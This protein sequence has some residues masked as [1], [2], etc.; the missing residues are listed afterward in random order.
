DQFPLDS[1]FEVLDV[2][3]TPSPQISGPGLADPA[4]SFTDTDGDG[5]ADLLVIDF[6]AVT[7]APD[8]LVD[9][10]DVLSVDVLAL[11]LDDPANMGGAGFVNTATLDFG[12]GTASDTAAV[13]I[14]APALS[15]AKG[16]SDPE[17]FLGDVIAYTVVVTNDEGASGPAFDVT[18]VDPIPP[19][20]TLVGRIMLTDPTGMTTV[21]SGGSA[22]DD[23][24]EV[25]IPVLAPG[26][27]VTVTY[28]VEIGFTAPVLSDI[29]NTVALEANSVP[30][31]P[32]APPDFPGV[33][34]SGAEVGR[35]V[36]LEASAVIEASTT[37]GGR[38]TLGPDPSRIDDARFLPVVAID[39]I[40][41]GGAEYGA[42][43]SLTLFDRLGGFLATR[44]VL[45][46]AAGQW[47]ALFPLVEV[48]VER[49]DFGEDFRGSRLFDAPPGTTDPRPTGLFGFE[50]EL[51]R[52]SI[53]A[54][55]GDDTLFIRIEE[56]TSPIGPADG[57][58]FNTRLNYAPATVPNLFIAPS[59]LDVSEVFEDIASVALD[60]AVTS[61]EQ[62]LAPGLNRFN[63]EFLASSARVSGGR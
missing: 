62:P 57:S 54:S 32:A 20:L 43:L 35:P 34:P 3:V 1:A 29:Q 30:A 26:E 45:A 31:D 27:S 17:P 47:I 12:T 24:L 11:V 19:E 48:G 23:T 50:P 2:I 55:I 46:D 8:N 53:G 51:R 14:V 59:V 5:Q 63:A 15:V 6:G 39:P 21:L 13:E 60:R 7:N 61:A 25:V 44:E 56:D 9:A 22:G 42:S 28:E 36:A 4:V 52:A 49:D 37:S 10:A 40:F 58:S 16:V 18:L 33:P 41:S 38:P